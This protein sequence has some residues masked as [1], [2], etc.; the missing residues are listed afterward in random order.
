MLTKYS[1]YIL[2]LLISILVVALYI[3]DFSFLVELEWKIQGL[4]YSVTN[5][6]NYAGDFT[7]VNIDEKSVKEFG[8]WP[9]DRDRV[10]DLL[11]AVGNGEP[12][13]VLMN[14]YF[15]YDASQD[16]LG[17]TAILAGQMSW[18]KNVI[19][20]YE[21]SKAEFR[22]DKISSPD[23]LKYFSVGVNNELGV[24]PEHATLLGRKIFLPPDLICEYAAGMGF[25]YN[26]YDTDRKIRWS[27]LV[28]HYEG[29]YYPSVELM[30][31]VHH[32]GMDPSMVKVKGGESVQLG[33]LEIVTNEKAEM[34]INFNSPGRTFNR[35]SAADVLSEKI[36][37]KSFK[38]KLVIISLDLEDETEY[39]STPVSPRLAEFEKTANIVENI[40]H[41]NL[42]KRMDSNPLVDMVILFGL[43]IVFA[44]VLPRVSLKFRLIILAG[45]F[46]VLVNLA[47][48]LFSSYSILT[49][50]L[51]VGIE[52]FFFLIASPLMD[53]EF[54]AKLGIIED[55]RSHKPGGLPKIKQKPT[56][57]LLKEDRLQTTNTDEPT[58]QV[59][60][61][62]SSLDQS[63]QLKK[64]TPANLTAD[65]SE[66]KTVAQQ[67]PGDIQ[68]STPGDYHN[69]SLNDDGKSDQEGNSET[70]SEKTPPFD[71]QE[72]TPPEGFEP[73]ADNSGRLDL[74]GEPANQLSSYE[75][76]IS[77]G[78]PPGGITPNAG[79]SQ[80]DSQQN[81]SMGD[82]QQLT[83]LGRYK[84]V[85]ELGK[86]AMGSVFKG[87]DP[88]INRNVA[89]KTIRLDF[90]SDPEEFA[91]L[92]ERLFREARAAGMLSHPNIVTIYDVGTE[93][94]L[95]YIAME[96]IKG[97]T[98]EEMIR[99][100]VKFN[101]RI[102]AQ[103]IAQICS[104]LE[105][106]HSYK[107]VHRDIKPAN[108]MVQ[109]DYTVKVMDF[110]IARV[111]STSMTRTGIAMGTP[112]YISPEQ[113]QGRKVDHRCDI[114][115]LGVMMY[116]M[117]VN[118]RPFTGENLTAL[119]YSIVN[120][121]P[122]PPSAVDS[123]IPP[124]FDRI[125][126]KS[127]KKNPDERFQKA[128]EISSALSDFIESFTPVRKGF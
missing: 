99:R 16:T 59:D 120:K 65:S 125:I 80:N 113:L 5:D 2:C 20:P 95:Q 45:S 3:N 29:F 4:L 25:K 96:Y 36:D 111:D 14:I 50:P 100:K 86:G 19:V 83:T 56:V 24:L 118:K 93:G 9:W 67:V 119:I 12:K 21:I 90:V 47:Y 117:L 88:A 121:E 69:I 122:E 41:G 127:L 33:G 46:F 104:A 109:Q 66:I 94:K 92:K 42:I 23:Y 63:D 17:Y 6:S 34:F 116:E 28:M 103:M 76:S 30:T 22:S 52:L 128:S 98:L 79:R 37:L 49:R 58:I 74:R 114:F 64:T 68:D 87:L 126:E 123:S 8:K 18:M 55:T 38:D 84:V 85:G 31:A 54:L 40:V 107:I 60:N 105:Y 112:N 77:S 81:F 97:A 35:V 102:V 43:G 71:E 108:I 75:Q 51:Y 15:D 13:T 62:R 7:L 39:F 106:A 73:T 48:V 78:T 110:G 32:L 115:S 72:D 26:V 89:L 124:L 27:P 1:S 57:K 82:S 70:T 11:A 10:A 53:N 44:F 101:L 61:R 91:E